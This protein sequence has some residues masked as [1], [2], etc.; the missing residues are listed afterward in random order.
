MSDLSGLFDGR[1]EGSRDAIAIVRAAHEGDEQA[2][3]AIIGPA[4]ITHVREVVI[5]LGAYAATVT[6]AVHGKGAARWLG[7][8]QQAMIEAEQD[9]AR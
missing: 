8:A 6:V 3:D 4:S 9:G 5:A 7:L 1:L 2:I